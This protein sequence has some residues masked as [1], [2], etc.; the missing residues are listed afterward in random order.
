[1][2]D[3]H[4]RLER[5]RR[6]PDV[7]ERE[8]RHLPADGVPGGAE[9][10]E[11]ALPAPNAADHSYWRGVDGRHRLAVV[12]GV[13]GGVVAVGVIG[14]GLF[15]ALSGSGRTAM[16]RPRVRSATQSAVP[17]SAAEA[18]ASV[19]PTGS[20]QSTAVPEA[21]PVAGRAPLIAYRAGGAI[22]VSGQYGGSAR[23]VYR[24]SAGPFA[25]SPNGLWLAAVDPGAGVL[26]IVDVASGT[27]RPVGPAS[28]VRPVWSSDSSFLVYMRT[29]PAGAGEAWRVGADGRSPRLAVTGERGRPLWRGGSVVAAPAAGGEATVI[30]V[31]SEGHPLRAGHPVRP[32]EV[33]P[34]DGLYFYVDAGTPAQDGAVVPSLR[35][36]RPDGRGERTLVA[37]PMSGARAV[38][39]E[40]M[41]SPD[42]SWLAYAEVGDDGFS[43]LFAIRVS[44][45][46]PVGLSPRLDGYPLGWSADGTEVFLVEGNALQ[47]E[48]TRVSAVHP[49]GSGRRVVVEG[50]GL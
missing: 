16:E 17:T 1:M 50:G 10:D 41:V 37:S 42:G 24:A 9:G 45:G 35:S 36:V 5:P 43:R 13:A 22:W 15:W 49:D 23:E 33:C 29:S 34:G 6:V 39:A 44:G 11:S 26:R 32:L 12:A 46:A 48:A 19:T 14:A 18:T 40:L 3:E 7:I 4:G 30:G 25:L 2:V 20:A 8:R 38:F 28:P 47:G 31:F 27:T 21:A